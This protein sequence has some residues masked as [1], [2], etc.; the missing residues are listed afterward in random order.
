MAGKAKSLL[1]LR[2]KLDVSVN[3]RFTQMRAGK[4]IAELKTFMDELKPL[5]D[6]IPNSGTARSEPKGRLI[7]SVQATAMPCS[8]TT[9]T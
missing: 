5:I 3:D 7:V 8:S 2:G 1:I 9:L 6:G 4:D